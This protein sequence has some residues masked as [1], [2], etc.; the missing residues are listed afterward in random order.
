MCAAAVPTA[1][2]VYLDMENG[3]DGSIVT[4]SRLNAA[5]HGTGGVWT[6]SPSS[7][8][9]MKVTTD[10]E[11]LLGAPVLVGAEAFTDRETTRGYAF[12]NSSDQE[13]AR[14]TF[15]STHARVS[16]GCFVRLGDFTGATSGSYDLIVMEG[17]GEF[18]VLNFQDFPDDEF[19]WQIHTQ[20]GTRDPFR[21]TPNTTYWV[22]LLWDQPNRRATLK[23]YD[24]L[25]WTLV[26]TASLGL[27][28]QPC[29]AVCFGRYD[30]HGVFS[31]AYHYYDDLVIDYSSAQFP[32]LPA[33]L[34]PAQEQI[35]LST[36]GA[37]TITGASDGAVLNVDRSYTLTAKPAPGNL[38]AGW[39][40]STSW[41]NASLKFVMTSNLTFTANFVTN[42]FPEV[43]GTYAGLFFDPEGA[44][45]RSSGYLRLT[46]GHSG[47]YSARAYLNG[48]SHAAS[49]VLAWDG[50]GACVFKRTGTNSLRAVFN[51]DLTNQTDRL[52]GSLEEPAESGA[53]WT[54]SFALHRPAPE[55]ALPPATPGRY[56][57]CVLP[58]PNSPGS[59]QGESWGTLSLST[60]RSISFAGKLADGTRVSQRTT[61]SRFG[62]WPL[63]LP[64]YRGKGS[65][66]CPAVLDTNQATTD[67]R[68]ALAWF[69]QAQ[70]GAKICPDG[71]TNFTSVIGSHYQPPLT[72]NGL[73]D[74][75][76][77]TLAFSLDNVT[78]A[79]ANTVELTPQNTIVN[80]G[81]DKLSIAVSKSRG[82]FSGSAMPPDGDKAIGFSGVLLQRQ[83]RG[84]GFFIS[85]NLSGSVILGP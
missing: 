5:T 52:D 64:L 17:G 12:R 65:L 18:I 77:G 24:A 11:P 84:A 38:F 54:A 43:K 60:R 45:Q 58:D 28:N 76:A 56:S 59:P 82:R 33:R 1:V 34:G 10:F 31:P 62:D 14:Y 20:A 4:A 70:T 80:R 63:Y 74:L 13:F 57:L 79:F 49:G 26:G 71:F 47:A 42:R 55:S 21:V 8:S 51:L 40:G 7:L 39:T 37:G 19:V 41:P 83:N 61:L 48:K 46:V 75:D 15:D 30:G 3:A 36:T 53:L 6:T 2:D 68:G 66:L 50:A 44:E 16:M 25:T 29:E 67:I 9:A 69:K 81:D 72:T 23:A 78:T 32:I 73:L 22:T 35:R 85:S 27:Q